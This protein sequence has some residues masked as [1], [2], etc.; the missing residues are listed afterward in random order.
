MAFVPALIIPTM[1][2][3]RLL[4]NSSLDE[5]DAAPL[6]A[7]DIRKQGVVDRM[8]SG[9]SPPVSF[10][11]EKN[12]EKMIKNNS[13]FRERA[14]ELRAAHA[15]GNCRGKKCETEVPNSLIGA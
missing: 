14:D 11:S 12:L 1:S 10:W 3:A 2:F 6:A 15:Q 7:S 9:S 4:R 5:R 8:V 13:A